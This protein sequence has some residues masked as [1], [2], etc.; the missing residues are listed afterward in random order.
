MSILTLFHTSHGLELGAGPSGGPRS[1]RAGQRHG[2]TFRA[3]RPLHLLVYF[4][5]LG[6]PDRCLAAC[7]RASLHRVTQSG[8]ARRHNDIPVTGQGTKVAPPGW[9]SASSWTFVRTWSRRLGTA[10][11]WRACARTMPS[12]WASGVM[13]IM[14]GSVFGNPV[15]CS[16]FAAR[17]SRRDQ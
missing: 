5:H 16:D 11:P 4:A 2:A 15:A 6:S 14:M 12:R 9:H 1:S 13:K 3:W 7:T 8:A 10:Y 17:G